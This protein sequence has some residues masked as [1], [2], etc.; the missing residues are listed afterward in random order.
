M[1]FYGTTI[2]FVSY[3]VHEVYFTVAFWAARS[4]PWKSHKN[5]MMAVY[6]GR[7][8]SDFNAATCGAQ[9]WHA[10]ASEKNPIE[11]CLLR[12]FPLYR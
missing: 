7:V 4:T 8:V 5:M 6:E 10:S 9:W 1:A 2:E 12:Y 3:R 11:G